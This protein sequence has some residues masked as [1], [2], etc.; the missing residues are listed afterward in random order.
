MSDSVDR[1]VVRVIEAMYQ[2]I[3]DELTVDDMARTAMYSKFHFSRM[4][5]HVT[6]VSPGRFLSAVR[7]QEAKRLLSTTSLSVAEISNRVGY[8]SLGTFSTRFKSSVG[9]TPTEYRSGGASWP[10]TVPRNGGPAATLSGVVYGTAAGECGTTCLGLFP[11]RVPHRS[12]VRCVVLARPGP[13][14][15]GDVP[16][17]SWYLLA[18]AAVAS[19][20]RGDS[21]GS[22]GRLGPIT[23][24]PGTVLDSLDVRLRP[25]RT[26]DLPVLQAPFVARPPEV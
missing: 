9:V 1:A 11:D 22:V 13:Y 14:L 24:Y 23:V 10:A 2:R 25:M 18:H 20:G 15:F 4:F 19:N 21:V 16:A 12:P 17:G 8:S 6:G 26:V 5:R 3:G 7:F